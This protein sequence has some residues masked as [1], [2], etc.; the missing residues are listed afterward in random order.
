MNSEILVLWKQTRKDKFLNLFICFYRFL[1]EK[2]FWP[3]NYAAYAELSDLRLID[4]EKQ[5]PNHKMWYTGKFIGEIMSDQPSPMSKRRAE[6]VV[7]S[8]SG[9][10][11]VQISQDPFWFHIAHFVFFYI[12]PLPFS[13]YLYFKGKISGPIKRLNYSFLVE[14]SKGA[15]LQ[16]EIPVFRGAEIIQNHIYLFYDR[17][18]NIEIFPPPSDFAVFVCGEEK[19]VVGIE[20]AGTHRD[21]PNIVRLML[22]TSVNAGEEVRVYYVP[23][24]EPI[25]DLQGNPA[26][27][28]SNFLVRNSTK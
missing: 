12:L 25:K 16:K 22:T 10:K 7:S 27:G 3:R 17:P 20:Y 15:N 23:R 28:F 19:K 14:C 9:G 5:T 21:F 4:K 18:L 2:F 26:Q 8:F 1:T 11:V 24:K 6:R 13:V